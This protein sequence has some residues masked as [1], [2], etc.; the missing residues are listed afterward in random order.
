MGNKF[1]PFTLPLIED[2][3][4]REVLEVL[5]SGWLTTGPKTKQFEHGIFIFCWCQNM[6]LQLNSCTAALH[7][8]LEAI[9]VYKKG[10]EVIIP[11]YDLCRYCRSRTLF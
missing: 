11:T 10:D 5:E 7:L 2:D 4:K 1:I 3:E 8:A 9:G 6:Q